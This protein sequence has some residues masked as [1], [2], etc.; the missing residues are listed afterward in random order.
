MAYAEDV[1]AAAFYVGET[2]LEY[3]SEVS[4][5]SIYDTELE[6]ESEVSNC[7]IWDTWVRGE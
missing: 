7:Y 4:N 2:E 6:C 1:C 3:E 5:S